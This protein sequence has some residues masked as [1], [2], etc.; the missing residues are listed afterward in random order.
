[1]SDGYSRRCRS[2]T[3]SFAV[4]RPI[5]GLLIF[6]SD[7]NSISLADEPRPSPFP[8]GS[9]LYQILIGQMQSD[10]PSAS[11]NRFSRS[12]QNSVRSSSRHSRLFC[13]LLRLAPVYPLA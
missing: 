1:M 11:D 4:S 3:T 12:S 8:L 9:V 5:L 6:E 13:L 7:W 2:R 10:Q